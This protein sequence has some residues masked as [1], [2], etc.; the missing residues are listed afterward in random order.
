MM[1]MITWNYFTSKTVIKK[2]KNEWKRNE[3]KIPKPFEKTKT[4]A[5]KRGR[6]ERERER[7]RESVSKMAIKI[8]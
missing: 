6:T 8:L 1:T 4:L 5:K 2:K 3:Y 7:W